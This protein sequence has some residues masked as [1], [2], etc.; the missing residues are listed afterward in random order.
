[1][2]SKEKSDSL[3][4]KHL[5]ILRIEQILEMHSFVNHKLT[6]EEIIEHLRNEYGIELERKA[7][8]RNISRLKE[9]GFDIVKDEK[10]G[11][12]YLDSRHFTDT[13]IIMLVGSVL[14]NREITE[15]KSKELVE[16]LCGLTHEFLKE[17]I[18]AI[19]SPA[20]THKSDNLSFYYNLDNIVSAI[21]DGFVIRYTYNKYDCT[22]KLKKSSVQT[23][24]PYQILVNNQIFYLKAYDEYHKSMVYHR[25]DRISDVRML[26]DEK[27]TPIKTAK[28]FVSG[29]LSDEATSLSPYMFTDPSQPVMFKI[30]A[31]KID[32]VIDWFGKKI[33]IFNGSE[34]EVTV[35]ANVSLTAMKYWAMQ[36]LDYVEVISPPSL[37]LNIAESVK[38]GAEK[39]CK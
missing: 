11:G 31:E 20:I 9:A 5:A 39:Y 21:A 17:R 26:E 13:E 36:Y 10:M 33:E 24:S 16:K 1:M 19:S 2:P 3:E 18:N 25:L 22:K 30:K 12:Y 4:S 14:A 23:V 34:D 6:Q 27:Y 35:R 8:A 15:K 32:S 37:R 29:T 28:K 7:V 38:K